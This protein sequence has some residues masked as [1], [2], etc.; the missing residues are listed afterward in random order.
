[1]PGKTLIKSYTNGMS[2]QNFTEQLDVLIRARYPMIY[3]V[4]FEELRVKRILHTLCTKRNAELITWS[5]TEGFVT[6]EGKILDRTVAPDGALKYVEDSQKTATFLFKDYHPYMKDP[7]IIRKMRDLCHSL[8]LIK[9]TIVFVS[10]VSVIPLEL[11]KEMALIDVPLPSREEIGTVYDRVPQGQGSQRSECIEASLG[12]TEEE[13]ENVFAKSYVRH[14]S[15]RVDEILSEKKQIVQKAGILDFISASGNFDGVGGLENLKSWL[16]KRKLGFSQEARNIKLPS[17]K[18]ILLVG[19]P[20]CGKSLTATCTASAWQLPLLRLDVGKVFSGL[21]GSSEENM[22]TALKT[23]ESVSPCILWV[24]EIEKGL[25]GMGG[26]GGGSDGGTGTRV[27][28]TFLTWMQEKT[29]PV[30]VFATANDISGLPP[31]L[32]RKGRFDEIFF[33]DAPQSSERQDILNIHL[34]KRDWNIEEFDSNLFSQ[35][36]DQFTGAEIEQ[37]LIDARYSAFF[38]SEKLKMAHLADSLKRTVPLARTMKEKIDAIRNW[39]KERA[40]PASKMGVIP[41]GGQSD[42][43]PQGSGSSQRALEI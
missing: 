7:G 32:L 5:R 37:G 10:P 17:P 3:C 2:V 8:K 29:Q 9:K 31:E 38:L 11:T 39:A 21:V 18:G 24:D 16:S 23:A 19:L 6:A 14:S 34:K 20:G 28:G 15:I 26:G 40:V 4:S 25:S 30:F 22:R 42:G 13:I 27:F 35:L 12:L 43:N 41:G 1:M 33:L 36:T